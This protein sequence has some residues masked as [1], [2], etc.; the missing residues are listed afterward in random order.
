MVELQTEWCTWCVASHQPML[1]PVNTFPARVPRISAFTFHN[2]VPSLL[3][4][5]GTARR[6]ATAIVLGSLAP[7]VMYILWEG[8][9]LGS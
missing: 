9:I 7:L 6:V 3:S 8:V 2:M 5:L 4:Y 1:I